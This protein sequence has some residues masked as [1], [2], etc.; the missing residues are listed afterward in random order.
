MVSPSTSDWGD[1]AAS[2]NLRSARSL[3]RLGSSSCTDGTMPLMRS[4]PEIAWV[5]PA[6]TSRSPPR[7]R[8][9]EGTAVTTLPSRSISTRYRRSSSRNP[10]SPTVFPTSGPPGD[11]ATSRVNSLMEPNFCWSLRSG[12]TRG[13]TSNITASPMMATGRPTTLIEKIENPAS[14]V[15]CWYC[16]LTTRLVLVPISVRVPPRMAE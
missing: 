1:S 9:S 15:S 10:A 3:L 5:S 14:P 4:R 16:P 7:S 13:I 8:S 6:N 2:T 12:N 11:T